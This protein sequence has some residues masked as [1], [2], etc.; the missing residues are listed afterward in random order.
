MK[1]VYLLCGLLSFQLMAGS[2]NWQRKADLLLPVQEIYPAVFQ[3]EIYVAGGLSSEL[4]KQ[5]GQMTAA[6]QIYNAKTNTWRYG[7]AL[8]E[9]RH[10]GQLV[11]VKE[12]LF[13][14]GGFIQANGGNWS[15]SA[16]V[17]KLDLQ[18]QRWL[19]VASLPQPL[20]E[21][22]SWVLEDKV[23]LLSG[24]SPVP[25][26]NA[27]WQDQAD[28]AVHWVFDPYKLT[29]ETAP[30]VPEAK[31]SAAAVVYEGK[32]YLL[33]GRQVQA[34]NKADVHSYDAKSK[35]WLAL[36]PMPE[37]QAGLAAAVFNGKL[38]ALGGEF[39]QQG[40]GV[41]SNLWVYSFTEQRWQQLG[42]MPTPRHGL[43]A[44]VLDNSIYLIGG[45]TAAGLKQTSAVL[46]QLSLE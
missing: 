20:S 24:R 16:D 23:H 39:F 3:G 41:F 36:A 15:A 4:P 17:L 45:A 31:N 18:Q 43:G 46:E 25:E 34:G 7:P 13:L 6:V 42:Q 22:V 9:G 33:G 11:A 1:L 8:P 2:L 27:Q 14:F 19:K 32:G 12:Q 29:I 38:W 21:T 40:G 30:V 26:A 44:V 10:H 28:V 35:Q 37:A 5:Q